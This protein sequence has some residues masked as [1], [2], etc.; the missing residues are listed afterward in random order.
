[1]PVQS[2]AQ[3]KLIFTRRDQYGTKEKTPKKW[4]W[5]WNKDWEE[6]I[7]EN[8]ERYIPFNFTKNRYKERR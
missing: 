3:R 4:Q 8:I 1:M 5:I 6:S 2:D 7:E